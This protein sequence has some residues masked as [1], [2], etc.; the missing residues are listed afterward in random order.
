MIDLH[1]HTTYSDGDKSVAEILKMCENKIPNGEN[2]F[3]RYRDGV[4]GKSKVLEN[5]D[6]PVLVVFGEKDE[7]VLTQDIK[8]VE[9]Y[10][11][12]NIKNCDIQIIKGANHS[13]TNKYKEL[14]EIIKE[15]I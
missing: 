9:G 14:G 3:I 5:I 11:N 1:I 4:N 6:I 15:K 12:K 2:D 13:Y 8:T 10:L 7:E